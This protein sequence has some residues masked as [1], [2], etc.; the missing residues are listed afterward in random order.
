MRKL[1]ALLGMVLA[2]SA[3]APVASA[4]EVRDPFLPLIAPPGQEDGTVVQPADP[5]SPTDPTVPVP[6]DP[7]PSTGSSTTSW[8]GIAYLLVAFGT[9]AL[10]L[11]RV[12][13]P[14]PASVR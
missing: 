14:P 3:A 4:Q 11:S 13:G 1:L 8:T 6:T 9:G 5:T 7:L 2:L 12:L 10:M